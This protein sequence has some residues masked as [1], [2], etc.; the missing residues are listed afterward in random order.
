MY[1]GDQLKKRVTPQ[2]GM[3]VGDQELF[4][5]SFSK[6]FDRVIIVGN[7][8]VENG[9]EPLTRA[10]KVSGSPEFLAAKLAAD[11]A[12]FRSAR[13]R[14]MSNLGSVQNHNN[15]DKIKILAGQ[16]K[17]SYR[18][19]EV[20]AEAYCEA[21]EK[22]TIFLRECKPISD[23]LYSPSTAVITTNWDELLWNDL[24]VENLI[25]LH[26]RASFPDSLILPSEMR[27]DDE[28]YFPLT[29]MNGAA[30]VLKE[31]G[32]ENHFNST[33]RSSLSNSELRAQF[34]IAHAKE[35][36]VWGLAAHPYDA[37]L[38]NIISIFGNVAPKD[39]TEKL[40]IINPDE[41]ARNRIA[42][43]LGK[44]W[45]DRYD[46]NIEAQKWITEEYSP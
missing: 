18:Q 27:M 30:E 12:H 41:G 25:Q 23:I 7:G 46:W 34:W 4:R 1:Q 44:T 13:A 2:A 16:I 36:F 10:L 26:G 33:D 31:V 35:L 32:L 14:L 40:R 37:E 22:K 24:R 3:L 29:C 42:S 6:K 17:D 11:A 8:A 15:K 45:T 28:L 21:V 9:W 38:I 39:W 5:G 43:L 20:L 19:R